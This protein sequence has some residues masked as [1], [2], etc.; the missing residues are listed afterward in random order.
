MWAE[1]VEMLPELQNA[2]MLA[3]GATAVLVA[4]VWAGCWWMEKVFYGPGSPLYEREKA[5]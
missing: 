5:G 1:F 2:A 4:L 3:G